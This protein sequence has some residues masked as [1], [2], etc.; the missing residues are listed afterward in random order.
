MSKF[1]L[2]RFL[3]DDG[4]AIAP[5]Y[6][7]ALF[8]LIGIAGVGWD[9]GR[10]MAMDSELQ[11]AADQAAL[12]AATQLDGRSGAMVRA[13]DAANNFLANADS[14]WVNQTR[15][16][17]DGD[18]RA[19]SALT[20][21]FYDSYDSA[22][23]TFG[24][25]ITDDANAADANVV[26]V[27]VNGREAFFALTPIVGRISSGD[28]S[29]NAVAGLQSATC[30]VPPL[31]FCAPSGG[32][33]FPTAS[34]IGTALD[35]REKANTADDFAP[36]NFDLLQINY[37]NIAPNQQ[38]RTLGLNSDLLGC[39]GAQL[40]TRPGN[41]D[42]ETEA[43]NT[44]FDQYKNPLSCGSN[45][46]F[47]PA[48]NVR[49]NLVRVVR[50]NGNGQNVSCA[51]A[52]GGDLV[53]VKDLDPALGIS[54]PGY[55]LDSC[56]LTGACLSF[57]DGSWNAAGYMNDTHGTVPSVV[58]DLN[59]DGSIS[60]YEV[61]EWEKADPANR[62]IPRELARVQET[63]PNRT[64]LYCSNPNPVGGTPVVASATQKDRRLVTVASVDC[65]DLNGRAP[66][67]TIKFVDLFML[68]PALSNG[69]NTEIRA[70]IVGPASLAGG[71]SAF[72]FFGRN[73]PVLLR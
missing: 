67:T 44:R 57:G 45:G 18:G 27:T 41:R 42:T 16:A 54:E 29:A 17:N 64:T 34:D 73:K 48:E 59:S 20:F 3:K 53:Q 37:D 23:D 15:L 50:I 33:D 5:M 30:N 7:V 55:P 35:L 19:I 47:C 28:I 49:S 8:G 26:S 62:M 46:N 9:Y 56:Q 40:T 13:R 71:G 43:F 24:T 38:N 66:I 51:T 10:M 22:A 1:I 68:Q 32:N 4:A 63:S 70:E 36:G 72:Q 25:E 58:P 60:R 52:T 12:A 65:T 61:Y 39:T 6:A 69:S 11:N 21:R 2:N 31:M 14:Q